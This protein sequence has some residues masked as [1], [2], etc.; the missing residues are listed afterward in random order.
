MPSRRDFLQST[1]ASALVVSLPAG[2]LAA[3]DHSRSS[4]EPGGQP[5]SFLDIRRAPDRVSVQL[6]AGHQQ[7]RRTG[8]DRWE[9]GG[10]TISVHEA[11]GALAVQLMA[12]S[13][14]VERIHLRW[15]GPLDGLQLILGDAWE[16]G[17]GD[18]EWR[19]FVP[20][21]IMPWYAA[22]FDGTLTHAWGVQT[23]ASAFCSW[24]LDPQGITLSADVRSGGSG[25]ELGPRTLDVCQVLCRAGRPDE[26]A[27]AA[28][29][30]FCRV[31]CPNPRLVSQP[32]YGSNDWYWAYG[33]NSAETVLADAGHIVEL[34]PDT[35]NRPF[36]V[37][38]DGWQPERG[39]KGGNVGFWDRGNE[40]FPDLP[41]LTS[42]IRQQGARPGIWIRPL[43]APA[44]SPQGW[45]LPRDQQFLDPTIPEVRQKIAADIARL[46]Q[47]GFELIKHDYST[48]DILGR[49]GFEMG[50]DLTKSGWTFA[51][52]PSR[53]TAEVINQLYGTIRGAAAES[54]IIGCN[55]VSHL[56]A[57]MFELCR[58]GDDT[59]GTDWSRTRKMG[60]NTLAFRGVQ[61]GA[62]YG[63]DPDCV[64]V[65]NDIPWSLN[66]QWLD[67]AARSGT[68]LFVSLAPN[69]LG[70][71]QRRDLR[72]A[73]AIAATPQPLG[74]PLNWQHTTW[75]TRWKLMGGQRIYDWIPE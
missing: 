65:T 53:T 67:L 56:S 10:V 29:R 66:R 11:A 71:D 41:A 44:D 2:T 26:S 59:S 63:V 4:S 30:A 16:R 18:L 75:P 68:M 28:L 70:S 6:A 15:N 31:M 64:G 52:G 36:V 57:G 23:G 73:L 58:A 21:R 14:A 61:H 33:K 46:H 34:S 1:A 25:V 20:D 69:A 27:F 8:G 54:L 13:T 32:V 40:K 9:N 50:S 22:G 45:R 19:G 5:G 37:I 7:L 72:A 62:F 49:W 51:S 55:T 48:A 74:E 60:V 43:L 3:Q 17:Y 42:S 39:A 38:D 35:S 12:P 24:Q 47:W